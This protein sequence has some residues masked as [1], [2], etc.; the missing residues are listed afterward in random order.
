[1]K[2]YF[3]IAFIILNLLIFGYVLIG[4]YEIGSLLYGSTILI[5]QN[6]ASAF[7]L[8]SYI[9]IGLNLFKNRNHTGIV[10]AMTLTCL[11]WAISLALY[12]T[13]FFIE[14][15][16]QLAVPFIF[17]IYLF[18]KNKQ[19]ISTR[20]MAAEV[21]LAVIFWIC[22]TALSFENI[23][24]LVISIMVLG[25]AYYLIEMLYPMQKE[26]LNEV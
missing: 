5:G 12:S 10:F 19:N 1:M 25:I 22:L 14:M 20:N 15:G 17:T 7:A 11:I 16:K 6:I 8:A 4:F 24:N 21:S 18:N 2:D 13:T 23:Y 3:S 9:Y 26:V